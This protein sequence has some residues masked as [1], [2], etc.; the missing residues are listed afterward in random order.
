MGYSRPS[1]DVENAFIKGISK[2]KGNSQTD[3]KMLLLFGNRIAEHR[4]DGLYITNC[5]WKTATTK[6]HLNLL[7]NVNIFQ[8]KKIWYLNGDPWDGSW[9]KVM[10]GTPPARGEK[11]KDLIDMTMGYVRTDG[12]RGYSQPKFA[13]AGANDTGSWEDSPCPSDVRER[14]LKGFTA[15]LKKNG[16]GYE[17][18]VCETSNVFCV[19]VYIVVSEADH[20]K[21]WQLAKDYEAGDVRLFYACEI[22]T[23]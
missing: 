19:H 16:I 9:I 3:G 10:D 8:S 7:P 20:P 11:T 14:E 22:L 21:A 1:S 5:G 2:R 6:A 4:E 17:T 12:W 13:V 18:K 15:I 23:D